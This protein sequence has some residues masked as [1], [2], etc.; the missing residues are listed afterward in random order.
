M[1]S[2]RS[3]H[4]T[5][6]S[7]LLTFFAAN[8]PALASDDDGEDY[9]VK[10]RVVR[11]SLIKGE[12][13]LKRLANTDWERAR[14]NYPLVEGDT[15]ATSGD[16]QVEIQID[17]RN[18]VRVG[19]NSILRIVTLRDEGV[20]LSLVEGTTSLRLAKFDRDHEYFEIDAPKT[21]LAAEKKG[22]YRIDVPRDGR[23]RLTVRD[24]GRA[25][26]YSETSGFSLR[27]GRTAELIVSGDDTGDWE[28]LAAGG[29]DSWDN[30]I[31]DRERYLAQRMRY[32]TQYYDNYVWG[33][34][35]LDAYG[36]WAYVNDYGW[37]WRPHVTVINNYNNWAPYRYG[38]WTWFNPYG[39]T[40]V[41]YEPWGWAPY[42]YGRWVYHSNYW[43]WCPRSQYY[44]HRSWWR[45]ALVAFHISF[46]R[47][48]SWYP[49]SYHHRD[50]RSRHFGRDRVDRLTPLR[51]NDLANLRRVNPAYLRAVTTVSARDFGADSGR[52]RAA[53]ET[54]AR[55]VITAEPL[56]GDLPVRPARSPESGAGERS[57]RFTTARPARVAPAIDLPERSTGA[58][59][60]IPGVALDNELRRTRVLNG[61][62]LRPAI[63]MDN[64]PNAAEPTAI[65]MRP[66]GAVTRPARPVREPVDRSGESERRVQE[67]VDPAERPAVPSSRRTPID[68]QQQPDTNAPD[69]REPRERRPTTVP[70]RPRADEN[71]SPAQRPERPERTDRPQRIEPPPVERTEDSEPAAQPQRRERT[72]TPAPR[73]EP[74]ARRYEPPAPRS[75]TAPR[76]EPRPERSEPA[77]RHESP[78]QRS[79]PPRSDPQALPSG[80]AV[81]AKA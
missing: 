38:H 21:T 68:P 64:N 70:V 69:S 55:R 26:I 5:I 61:R 19:T 72:E 24:G 11:I 41:G 7:L 57:E 48:I 66:T 79:E 29:R 35:D 36:T 49:L 15:L 51:G 78:P 52:S 9:D 71:N 25:R 12:V 18:F 53:D 32:D 8:V 54:V 47:H 40:W 50:P 14:L 13:T 34:E 6:L 30:W 31:D 42:H 44:R 37:I 62:D 23:V 81:R 77:P 46:G 33:A 39:W 27:D 63:R 1:R 67:N 56:R 10:A 65:E 73:P 75:E 45:P 22:L 43:A 60:R 17:A 80:A 20:A 3:L 28:L 74:P 2:T 58:A 59:T 16:S 76:H 4:A